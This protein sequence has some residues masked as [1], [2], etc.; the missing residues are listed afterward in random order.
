MKVSHFKDK[1]FIECDSGDIFNIT[2]IYDGLVMQK[3]V[4]ER[5]KAIHPQR[6]QNYEDRRESPKFLKD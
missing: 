2:V 5:V 3:S 6:L 4:G 1:V